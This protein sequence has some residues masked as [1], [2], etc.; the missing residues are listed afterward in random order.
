MRSPKF[1]IRSLRNATIACLCTVAS[2]AW[3][4]TPSLH[5]QDQQF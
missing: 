3:L 1:W 5:A 2:V 4:F